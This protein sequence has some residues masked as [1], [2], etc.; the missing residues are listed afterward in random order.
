MARKQKL[1]LRERFEKFVIR[2]GEDACWGWRGHTSP[3]GYPGLSNQ[4]GP[5]FAHR[6]SYELHVGPIPEGMFVCHHCDNRV[7]TNPKHLF[8]GTPADN[9]ADMVS[10]M[11]HSY[12]S[13]KPQT[14]LTEDDVL[15]IRQLFAGGKHAKE[16]AEMYST[17]VHNIHRIA[18]GSRW[19]YAPGTITK[20]HRRSVRGGEN[21][22]S[23]KLNTAAVLEIR[24]LWATGKFTTVALGEM[25]G[26]N[27]STI[28]R[29]V[30]RETWTH[31]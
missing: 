26:V 27:N 4:D 12:G 3:A 25:Y 1:T 28:G 11:R 17:D 22:H 29:V 31:I 20:G 19:K 2:D 10:K 6:I 18:N 24:K 5:E 7:C 16:I 15:R 8:L 23:A 14:S 9:I 13:K 30:R 21:Q